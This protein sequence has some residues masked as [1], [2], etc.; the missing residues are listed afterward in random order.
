MTLYWVFEYYSAIEALEPIITTLVVQM[1]YMQ[2]T[3]PQ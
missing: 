2:H 1:A 3:G